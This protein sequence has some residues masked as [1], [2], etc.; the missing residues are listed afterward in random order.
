[1]LTSKFHLSQEADIISASSH[2]ERSLYTYFEQKPISKDIL[3]HTVADRLR[4]EL[5]T[6]LSSPERE[7][8]G[9][10]ERRSSVAQASIREA[11]NNLEKA[12]CATKQSGQSAR[13]IHR[14]WKN[15]AQI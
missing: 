3:K 1:L 12:G 7:S 2:D 9:D 4:A 14:S 13:V 8:S 15:F 10:L 5:V 11:L 6:G